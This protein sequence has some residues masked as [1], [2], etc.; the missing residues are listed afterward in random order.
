MKLDNVHRNYFS[1]VI[2]DC[3]LSDLFDHI[4]YKTYSLNKNIFPYYDLSNEMKFGYY[5]IYLLMVKHPL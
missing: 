1:F 5:P 3:T 4:C 2:Y